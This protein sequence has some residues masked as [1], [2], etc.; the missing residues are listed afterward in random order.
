[1]STVASKAGLL[2][3][4]LGDGEHEVPG[5]GVLKIR[6]LSRAEVLEVQKLTDIAQSD[7]RMISLA[8]VEP[9]L[10]E[11]DVKVWQE[12]SGAS[13]IEDLTKAVAALSGLAG[14][15]AKAAYQQFRDESGTGV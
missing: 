2:A 3:R 13:E 14:E 15:S 10:T 11:A 6:G 9:K 1:M 4:R 7:R 12:N 5:V 8:V